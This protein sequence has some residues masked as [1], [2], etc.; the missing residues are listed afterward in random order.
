MLS[1]LLRGPRCGQGVPTLKLGADTSLVTC[2]QLT[3]V[4]VSWVLLSPPPPFPLPGRAVVDLLSL[5]CWSS[6]G[7]TRL[8]SLGVYW[9]VCVAPTHG[10]GCFLPCGHGL[11]LCWCVVWRLLH[12][13]VA[14]TWP[15]AR[16]SH[17]EPIGR[18][19]ARSA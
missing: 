12:V 7:Q 11:A 4:L 17:S 1:W 9:A 18:S 6:F 16:N 13:V 3:Y 8:P 19:D 10:V 2:E 15:F 14:L 5:V